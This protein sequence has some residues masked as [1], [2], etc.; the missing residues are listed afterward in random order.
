M[1]NIL[2]EMQREIE[3]QSRGKPII[4][5]TGA[6]SQPTKG[7]IKTSTVVLS[8]VLTVVVVAT[9]VVAIIVVN[10]NA[11]HSANTNLVR[12]EEEDSDED[13]HDL[14]DDYPKMLD[15][16][17]SLKNSQQKND[18]RDPNFTLLEDLM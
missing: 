1:S 11:E 6:P 14:S 3:L 13:W 8:I 12:M 15:K 7:G 10:K 16:S 2:K 5:Q 4:I 9:V 18:N 17:K